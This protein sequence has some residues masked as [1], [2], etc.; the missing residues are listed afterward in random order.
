MKPHQFNTLYLFTNKLKLQLFYREEVLVRGSFSF[1]KLS[2]IDCTLKINFTIESLTFSSYFN[3]KKFT[4]QKQGLLLLKIQKQGSLVL[5]NSVYGRC[6]SLVPFAVFQR[7]FYLKTIHKLS[8]LSELLYGLG[9]V[10]SVSVRI[11]CGRA[12]PWIRWKAA[13]LPYNS[14]HPP[15]NAS[16]QGRSAVLREISQGDPAL[17]PMLILFMLFSLSPCM[18]QRLLLPSGPLGTCSCFT[19]C[20]C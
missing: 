19:E 8:P 7:I 17:I 14:F 5:N 2:I 20:K 10:P 6:N 12:Q 16:R 15:L 18:L 1:W 13:G 3:W 11:T 9:R 4:E